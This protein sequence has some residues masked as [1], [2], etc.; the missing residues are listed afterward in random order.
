MAQRTG[1]M[2]NIN[3]TIS[4]MSPVSM[5]LTMNT[6][7]YPNGTMT[8][9]NMGS[10]TSNC[11]WTCTGG[12]TGTLYTFFLYLCDENGNNEYYLSSLQLK[13]G[14]ITTGWGSFS[15]NAPQLAGKQIFMK[16]TTNQSATLNFYGRSNPVTFNTSYK[17]Y[18]VTTQTDG[19]G[20]LTAN[21]TGGTAGT[22][23][24]LTPT[25]G[26]NY[27]FKSY[28]I[29]PSLTITNNQ[30]TMPSSNVTVRASF[31]KD[32][33]NS[34]FTVRDVNYFGQ[35]CTVN[36]SNPYISRFRHYITWKV[37]SHT[38]SM[39]TNQG[40]TSATYTIP[41]EWLDVIPNSQAHNMQITVETYE[42]N[43]KI[44]DTAEKYVT[45]GITSSIRP[46]GGNIIVSPIR[47]I[48][49]K[50]V[51]ITVI[52]ENF[53]PGPY[54]T[55][56]GYEMTVTPS[57]TFT[58][59]DNVF[60]IP[61][62]VNT[63]PHTIQI[64]AIDSR[65]TKSDPAISTTYYGI[66]YTPPAIVS[67]SAERCTQN[68]T[69]DTSGTY[70]LISLTATYDP[71][72]GDGYDY[73]NRITINSKYYDRDVPGTKYTARNNMV[74]GQSYIIGGGNLDTDKTYYIEFTVT[75]NW[76][77]SAS[78]SIIVQS[79]PYSIHVKNGGLGV[80]FGKVCEVEKA[81]EIRPEWDLYYKGRVL[82]TMTG[83]TSSV[84][85]VTG[86]VP[87]PTSADRSKYLRGDGTWQTLTQPP[88]VTLCDFGTVSS[89]PVT[90]TFTGITSDMVVCNYELGTPNAFNSAITVTTGTNSVKLEGT[91]QTSS[92]ST[93]K[94]I[95]VTATTVVGT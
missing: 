30:F 93:V 60:T 92:S 57:E 72:S 95:L 55:I 71:L 82:T 64:K 38:Y 56:I 25:P 59:A 51:S 35:D 90:K 29:T 66:P 67:Y 3:Q 42:G 41:L 86:L 21:P 13:S 2:G 44:G 78:A 77:G 65:N 27:K 37:G 46:T 80:A 15:P 87:A 83:A 53:T 48:Q 40:E 1:W 50:S 47:S 4:M 70:A 20:T 58:Q 23:I 88:V 49:G 52:P 16:V 69:P 68:G 22:T 85:G 79:T 84:D 18:S 89:L 9:S 43:T 36:I 32:V 75:D 6:D 5:H 62:T 11:R 28:S 81:V 73:Q 12:T 74:S 26:T 19:N 91:M 39:W 76:S 17:T 14:S 45:I 33:T 31:E 54:A 61:N 7:E 8:F 94:L 63:G 34:T 24:T 10:G